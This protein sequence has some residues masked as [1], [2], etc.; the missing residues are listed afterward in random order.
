MEKYRSVF[1]LNEMLE[2][3]TRSTRPQNSTRICSDEE[4]KCVANNFKNCKAVR[5]NYYSK[6]IPDM[7]AQQHGILE[8]YKNDPIH[9]E[10]TMDDKELKLFALSVV[11]NA[12]TMHFS[13][14]FDVRKNNRQS[15]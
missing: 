15:K 7:L 1:E 12:F 14:N 13:S 11:Q 9:T 4:G 10:Y 6:V 2:V 5:Y 3:C 8:G